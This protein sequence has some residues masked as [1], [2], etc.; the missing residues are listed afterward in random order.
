ML[1]WL[2]RTGLRFMTLTESAEQAREY[3][4]A[5]MLAMARHGVPPTPRNFPVWY[6]YQTGQHIGLSRVIDGL[7]GEN[8]TLTPEQIEEVCRELYGVDEAGD[9]IRDTSDRLQATLGD[10]LETVSGVSEEARH[11]GN[12]LADHR[13]RLGE[14]ITKDEMTALADAAAGEAARMAERS[15]EIADRLGVACAD[16]AGLM[17]RLEIVRSE[18]LKDPLTGIANR[19]SF[20]TALALLIVDAGETGEP[21]SVL[22]AD[23]DYLKRINETWG[24]EIGDEVIRLVGRTVVESVR[25]RDVAA[26]YDGRSFAVI[27]PDTS[28]GHATRV[29][30]NI[31]T[32]MTTRSVSN[33]APGKDLG[34]VTLSIGVAGYRPGE[35]PGALLQRADSGLYEARQKGRDQVV[36]GCAPE[37]RIA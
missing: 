21:L 30:E 35:T 37:Y 36:S 15:L 10:I 23:I 34:S 13:G 5:A 2:R 9:A 31:R 7:L 14:K 26:R 25:G 4:R 32:A 8:E 17:R 24:R 12:L 28:V 19:K 3:A 1:Q 22:I 18:A 27:L 6:A 16:I 29:A 33:Q 20:D 11:F